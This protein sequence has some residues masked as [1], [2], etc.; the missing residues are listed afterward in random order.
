M[1]ELQVRLFGN[2][3]IQQNGRTSSFPSG[4]ALELF[5]Y[6]LIHRDRAHTR[7]TLSEVLWPGGRSTAAK[8]Y[9][10]QAL[11]QLN[12]MVRFG[13][14]RNGEGAE[15]PLMI[16]SGWVRIN[17]NASWW[18][19]VNAFERV[20]AEVR[21][22]AGHDLSERQ[23]NALEDV[24][25]LYRGDLLATWYQD[26]C[27][28]ERERLQLT[29]LAMLDQLMGYCEAQRRYAK[30]LGLGQVILRFD[31]ARE[32]THCQ[33]MRL[34]YLAGDRTSAI[35]QYERC[36]SVM[37]QEFGVQPSA[38]TV[39]LYE[40]IR[41]DR[42][43]GVPRQ[44]FTGAAVAEPRENTTVADLRL[45]LDQIQASLLALH[46]SV[47]RGGGARFEHVRNGSP[48]TTAWPLGSGGTQDCP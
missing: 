8:K 13:S 24:L 39:A 35:R 4:K 43:P 6:L 17:P 40:Q 23:A 12:R 42:V 14:D 30:G 28:R 38:G 46:R 21:E 32:S 47:L 3:S 44:Q 7:E 22:T 25:D 2:V 29:Y 45:R 15:L 18:L 16:D 19:D 26:W 33:L 20:Y 37:S 11:W 10:R 48:E 41:A 9:L 34:H 36:A 1:P 5:C 31:P 27:I